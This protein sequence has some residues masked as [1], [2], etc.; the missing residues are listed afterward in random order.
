MVWRTRIIALSLLGALLHL[1]RFADGS[2]ALDDSWISFR[3]ARTFLQT[4]ALTFNG[5]QPPVEGMTNLLWTLMSAAWIAALPGQ[6]PIVAA[7][8][9][10]GLLHLLTV[11]VILRLV[12]EVVSRRAGRVE[13]AMAAAG[14]LLVSSGTFTA[15]AMS[16]LETPLWLLLAAT[17]MLLTARLEHGAVKTGAALGTVLGLWG[18]TR[19]EGVFFGAIWLGAVALGTERRRPLLAAVVTFVAW[20]IA[21]EALRWTVYGALV[22]NTFHAKPPDA[23]KGGAYVGGF[24]LSVL[25]GLGAL[26]ALALLRDRN[27]R[28]WAV[29]A[30]VAVAATAWSGGDWMPGYRRLVFAALCFLVL[31]AAWVGLA[32]G[33]RYRVAVAAVAA[34]GVAMLVGVV[35]GR[36]FRVYS[37]DI[38]V[39]L[40]QQASRSG[41]QSIAAVDIGKL[42]WHFEGEIFDIIGLTDAHIASM[43]GAHGEKRWDDAYFRS[44]SPELVVVANFAPMPNPYAGQPVDLQI[45][46]PEIPVFDSMLRGGGYHY[47]TSYSVGAEQSYLVFARDDVT[48]PPEIWG[49]PQVDL[50]ALLR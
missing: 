48:L 37:E 50:L 5:G 6:D 32:T 33:R 20:I 15:Y 30:W 49:A 1:L 4:G 3:I 19:P 36:D 47:V 9:V 43:P 35:T 18:W 21:L 26:P 14:L 13:H 24:F 25:G 12:E 39:A 27:L 42:G 7:R 17:G 41:V 2:T 28:V 10:G 40:A 29:L 8:W 34:S 22:P 11:L 23:A 45:R 46:T 38:F 16:G 44:R 31:G